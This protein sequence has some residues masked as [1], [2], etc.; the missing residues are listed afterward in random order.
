M[1]WV[2]GLGYARRESIGIIMF[3]LDQAA[4][5]AF[6]PDAVSEFVNCWGKYYRYDLDKYFPFIKLGLDLQE[7]DLKALLKWKDVWM[8]SPPKSGNGLNPRVHKVLEKRQA[9][10]AFRKDEL[11]DSEFAEITN[12]IFPNGIVWQLFLFHIARPITCPIA[13]QHVFR[14]YSRFSG[15]PAPKTVGEF[16]GYSSWFNELALRFRAQTRVDDSDKVAMLKANKDLDGA[17]MAF[18]Q[19]LKKYDRESKDQPHT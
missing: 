12:R 2:E 8:L 17:L 18:G 1:P 9:I 4:F 15:E 6:N 3:T 19:F 5:E 11:K 10:N 14:A 13:D 7:D 16:A